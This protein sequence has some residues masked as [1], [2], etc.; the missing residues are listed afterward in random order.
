MSNVFPVTRIDQVGLVVR[1]LGD[2][3]R[4]YWQM[5]GIGPWVVYTYSYPLVRDMT[6][7]GRPATY[8]MRL[9]LT[10]LDNLMI[11]LIQPLSCESIYTEHLRTKG[12][13]LHHVGIFVESLDQGIAEATQ[14]G[15]E[16]LQSG[17]GY[18]KHGDGGYAYLDTEGTLGV[19]LELI[20]LPQ[21]RVPP[22]ET[23]P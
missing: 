17:R 7:R 14:H 15:Y 22:E 20:E 2:A 23:F 5:L 9:A 4:R 10:Q 13:G 19:I 18:G 3:M 21:E 8:S 1:D 12:E 16:V 6:Y 11:E